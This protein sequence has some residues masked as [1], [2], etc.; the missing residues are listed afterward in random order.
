M[1]DERIRMSLE[2]LQI[3]LVTRSL[4]QYPTAL[5]VIA[6]LDGAGSSTAD[7]VAT[8]WLRRSLEA[9]KFDIALTGVA[10]LN[11]GREPNFWNN[12]AS[13]LTR[14][15]T[16]GRKPAPFDDLHWGMI[17][18]QTLCEAMARELGG[19]AEL[20]TID[21]SSPTLGLLRLKADAGR[22]GDLRSAVLAFLERP[23]SPVP[24]RTEGFRP[25]ETLAEYEQSDREGRKPRLT[26]QV[27]HLLI[28]EHYCRALSIDPRAML[29]IAIDRQT[30]NRIAQEVSHDLGGLPGSEVTR[31]TIVAA[32]ERALRKH[33][34]L[35]FVSAAFD[36]L[37][38]THGFER[39]PSAD[40]R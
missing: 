39:P 15:L 35:K 24:A 32:H 29:V 14:G 38:L 1:N 37:A 19:A 12:Y 26:Y 10:D 18:S 9:A 34:S 21:S 11:Y 6:L 27:L 17:A 33:M 5:T 16:P 3:N 13:D 7:H 4:D 40:R 30:S 8:E 23:A 2:S 28:G 22:L 20:H 25:L 31:E 36:R